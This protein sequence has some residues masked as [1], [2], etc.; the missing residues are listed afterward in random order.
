MNFYKNQ[1][2]EMKFHP[3]DEKRGYYEKISFLSKYNSKVLT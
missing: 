3:Y 1:L 2:L